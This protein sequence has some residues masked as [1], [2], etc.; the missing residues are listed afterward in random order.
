MSN[1]KQHYKVS[2]ELMTPQFIRIQRSFK[3]GLFFPLLLW[4]LLHCNIKVAILSP[5]ST[6]RL[7]LSKS[8]LFETIDMLSIISNFVAFTGH[9]LCVTFLPN[10]NS[11]EPFFLV[12]FF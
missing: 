10:L 3:S 4:L 1:Y 2:W 8:E 11:R 5:M 12:R 9:S 6:D 7:R